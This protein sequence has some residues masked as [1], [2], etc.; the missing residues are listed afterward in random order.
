[1]GAASD[2]GAG[3]GG[4]MAQVFSHATVA[5]IQFTD[6]G[7]LAQ[8]GDEAGD[9]AVAG[10]VVRHV[11]E[12]AAARAVPYV[13]ILGDKV[14]MA[15]GFVATRAGR[16]AVV[17]A[18]AALELRER[19][20]RLFTS[21]GQRLEF[22]IGIDTGAVVGASLGEDGEVFNLWGDATRV[23]ETMAETGIPGAAVV[24]EPSYRLLRDRFVFRARGSFF[25]S[26]A[27]EMPTYLLASRL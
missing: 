25:L 9:G 27:G 24:T 21:L 7:L 13:R 11:E 14:V 12:V 16:D 26:G 1:M 10:L 5:T 6:A 22:R 18:E 8:P 15:S 19:L 23:S 3:E 4:R 2:A 20:A 17:V